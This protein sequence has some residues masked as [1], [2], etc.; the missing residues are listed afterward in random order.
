MKKRNYFIKKNGFTAVCFLLLGCL[1][2]MLAVG[3]VNL[4]LGY[5]IK[6]D[7]KE[8]TFEVGNVNT[9][10]RE[11][12]TPAEKIKENVYIENAGNV[13][14]FVRAAIL[15]YWK[16]REG[17]IMLDKPVKGTDYTV[18]GP[19]GNWLGNG[20]AADPLWYYTIALQTSGEK[21]KTTAL[22]TKCE[23]ISSYTDGRVLVADIVTQAVQAEPFS[24]VEDAWKVSV[25]EISGMISSVA[26]KEETE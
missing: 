14:V 19:G 21:A 3:G 13:P 16:D 9:V 4:T 7:V 12:F 8:N 1:V 5:F 17:K 24:A 18:S 11:T 26:V 15:V 20:D 10:I 6:T 23:D 25:S 2:T 22:I